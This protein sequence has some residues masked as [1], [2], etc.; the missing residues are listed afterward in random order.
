M[1]ADLMGAAADDLNCSEDAEPGMT[2][3]KVSRCGRGGGDPFLRRR[4]QH[5]Q[6]DSR[7]E[8][9]VAPGPGEGVLIPARKDRTLPDLF[10]GDA[11]GLTQ[12]II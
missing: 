5:N 8:L 3:L 7:R 12:L 1:V 4:P 2:D 11:L 10:A 9:L 6:P